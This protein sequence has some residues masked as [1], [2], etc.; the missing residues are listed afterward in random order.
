VAD[1][2]TSTGR[3][4]Q[5]QAIGMTVGE[6]MIARPKTLS[7]DAVVGDVRRVFENPSVRTVLLA[8]HG[9]FCGAIERDLLP[10]DAAAGEPA[11]RY[12][13]TDPVTVTPAMSIPEAIELLDARSEPRLVVL[14]EQGATL[15]GLLCFNRG[16]SGFCVR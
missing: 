7:A 4:P 6:V 15:V 2:E 8:D 9:V 13:E 1:D 12:A 16:S 14:D 5:A 3:I 10:V 11:V